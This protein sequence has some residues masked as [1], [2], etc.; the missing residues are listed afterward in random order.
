MD[1]SVRRYEGIGMVRSD[2][3]TKKG[4]RACCRA[5]CGDGEVDEARR[6]ASSS[7]L[8]DRH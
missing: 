3:V 8:G 5:G 1:S 2:E 7:S 4:A 6:R